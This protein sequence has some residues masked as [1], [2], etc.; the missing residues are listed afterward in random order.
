VEEE[1]DFLAFYALPRVGYG[2]DEL[3]RVWNINISSSV[4]KVD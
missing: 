4:R 1:S 2:V 3:A